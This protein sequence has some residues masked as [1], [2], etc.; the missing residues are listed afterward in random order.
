MLESELAR[1][2]SADVLV[3]AGVHRRA[4]ILAPG[5]AEVSLRDLVV[6][7]GGDLELGEARLK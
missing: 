4:V 5:V 1:G 2:T 6:H 3:R 7:D